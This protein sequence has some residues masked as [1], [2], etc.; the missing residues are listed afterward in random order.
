LCW[1]LVGWPVSRSAGS[2]LIALAILQLL[3]F[4]NLAGIWLALLGWFLASAATAEQQAAEL[5]SRLDGLRSAPPRTRSRRF[6]SVANST[7]QKIGS[8]LLVRVDVPLV[9]TG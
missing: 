2:V 8:R 9:C 4:G 7:G 3:V 5:T 6:A 1:L